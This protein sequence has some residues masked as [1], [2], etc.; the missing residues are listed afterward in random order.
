MNY[1]TFG[2]VVETF[3]IPPILHLTL[4]LLHLVISKVLHNQYN[5]CIA[6]SVGLEELKV[7]EI[8]PDYVT[9]ISS[10]LSWLWQKAC[11]T[12]CGPGVWNTL[13]FMRQ[14]ACNEKMISSGMML[15][16]DP[17]FLELD[18]PLG[19][20]SQDIWDLYWIKFA[21]SSNLSLAILQ[22]LWKCNTISPENTFHVWISGF[23]FSPSEWMSNRF[24]LD[25]LTDTLIQ[26]DIVLKGGGIMLFCFAQ[27]N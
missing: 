2:L 14:K 7:W 27:I 19:T 26:P 5:S 22:T 11:F 16:A 21:H 24:F 10:G 9:I 1:V 4:S 20:K 17:A 15:S 23:V 12:K 18:S 8:N 25:S 13:T 6:S 3:G